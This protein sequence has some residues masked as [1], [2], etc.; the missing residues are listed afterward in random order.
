MSTMASI[1]SEES[2]VTKFGRG[3]LS[4]LRRGRILI[5]AI[6]RPNVRNAFN[7][8]V[9]LDLIDLMHDVTDDSSISAIVLTGKGTYFSS[10]ADLK[11]TAFEP[12]KYENASMV[13]RPPAKLVMSLLAF[14]KIIVAAVNGPTVG[15]ACTILMHCDL[16][17]CSDRATFWA[18]FTRLALGTFHRGDYRFMSHL[19]KVHLMQLSVNRKIVVLALNSEFVT[20]PLVQTVAFLTLLPHTLLSFCSSRGMFF[21]N[22]TRSHGSV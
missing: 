12:S 9:Y 11:S 18:P 5:A 3:T 22:I 21:G 8:D 17:I 7:D 1:G 10:G 15:I 2:T 13:D 16:V 20:G 6:D 14:P 19:H 4:V